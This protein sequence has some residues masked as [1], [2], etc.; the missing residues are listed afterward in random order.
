MIRKHLIAWTLAC[1]AALA[2]SA[3]AGPTGE[4]GEQGNNGDNNQQQDELCAQD[5]DCP[6][7]QSCDVDSGQC[8]P[9]GCVPNQEQACPCQNNTQGVQTCQEDGTFGACQ[10]SQGCAPD[11]VRTFY[12][13][14]DGDGFGDAESA[15]VEDCSLPDGYVE[16]KLDC[17]DGAAAISPNA[18]EVIGD[19]F[20]QDCDGQDLCY[21]DADEDGYHNN[22]HTPH[23]VGGCNSGGV[24]GQDSPGGDCNDQSAQIHP[25]QPELPGDEV[26]Q[27]CDGAELCYTDRDNDNYRNQDTV[28]SNNLSCL[29]PGE[30]PASLPEGDCDDDDRDLRP[31]KSDVC[32][33]VDN[34]CDGQIDEDGTGSCGQ[35][36]AC[37]AGD[38]LCND[39]YQGDGQR[40]A[41][42]NECD[43]GSNPCPQNSLCSNEPGSFSCSCQPG[44]LW[45]G[46]RCAD[47]DEC[48]QDEDDCG[49][50]A[51]CAN[52]PG[53]F[54]CACNEGFQGDGY[55]CTD[56]NECDQRPTPCEA[57]AECSNL[58]GGF[59][60]GCE[61]GYE[62]QGAACVDINECDRELDDCGA[63]AHCVNREG[64]FGCAC[65]E[66]FQ[67]D[68]YDCQ[69]INE[70]NLNES[71]C[72]EDA[73]CTNTPGA[74]TC[75]CDTGYLGDGY[76][77]Q[78]INE[79]ARDEDD[80][81][82]GD[83]CVNL[84]G[85]YVC[86]DMQI[87]AARLTSP[88]SLTA[89][90]GAETELLTAR[91]FEAGLTDVLS[92]DLDQL[93]AQIGYGPEGSDPQAQ[94]SG[95]TWA[96]AQ[97]VDNFGTEDGYGATL[98][99]AQEGRYH[100]TFRFS[101]D[102]ERWTVAD[103]D[104][105]GNGYD[106][107]RATLLEVRPRPIG[108]P[109]LS[110]LSPAE[111]L[112]SGGY[113]VTLRGEGFDREAQVRFG[114]TVVT[115]DQI[116]ATTLEVTV[117]PGQ[118]GWVDV[119]V[120]QGEHESL[121]PEGFVYLAAQAQNSAESLW[122][123]N[124]LLG[125]SATWTQSNLYLWL[126]AEAEP[127]NAVVLYLDTDYGQ[128]TGVTNLSGVGEGALQD[129]QGSVDDAING[130][131]QLQAEGF[132]AEFAFGSLGLSTSDNGFQDNVGWR[133]IAGHP[134]DF[135]W[136]D[137]SET[138][139][140]QLDD[141]R[142]QLILPWSTLY[143]TAQPPEGARLGLFVRLTNVGGAVYDNA[144]TLPMDDPEA[145][146]QVQRVLSLEP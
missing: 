92:G 131:L 54:T 22:A 103:R 135:A 52:T 141:G 55:T 15:G 14:Q 12:P 86:R 77:C 145:P 73:F 6:T 29:D 74:F 88:A 115:P 10:C 106:P 7:G 85:G 38:C 57:N 16:N 33:N 1:G 101:L 69:D 36:A 138:P 70:C 25:G 17:N 63:N 40:C 136:I 8:R 123:P 3:C 82:E 104:G 48:E 96:P 130:T 146:A 67:G 143:G 110:S 93:S 31:G 34:D 84:P 61:P 65:D 99:I 116:T 58:P 102:G 23:P 109:S 44:Y 117:P 107:A 129:N 114:Q 94:G 2:L 13:D 113:T 49:A 20:D 91:V 105:S 128:S 108:Q 41:D 80:C 118:P 43:D 30:A 119:A 28:A 76:D 100:V 45:D 121:R 42:I 81:Q 39:G 46:Q 21:V 112:A 5:S 134:E 83:D 32:D 132:G 98:Q 19:G 56:I 75:T 68:G 78:D 66:G 59:S 140:S 53:G 97:F 9:Q 60:C 11:Q 139:I 126:S 120:V 122:G 79:C 95:W 27:N 18:P 51:G 111:G 47:I 142:L 71:D 24:A 125:L 37:V 124:R 90:P 137:T 87:D 144:Q 26:D 72:G 127:Q 35:D 133:L 62:T 64:G 89:E 50:N 4:D